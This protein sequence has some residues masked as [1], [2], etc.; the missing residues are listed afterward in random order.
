[1]HRG[2]VIVAPMNS[3][4]VVVGAEKTTYM[5]LRVYLP[6][7]I[8]TGIIWLSLSPSSVFIYVYVVYLSEL[9]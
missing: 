9:V 7:D 6:S 8:F 3:S 5:G 1:M 2:Q 4:Q